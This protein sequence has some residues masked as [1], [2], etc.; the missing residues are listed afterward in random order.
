MEAWLRLLHDFHLL[1]LFLHLLNLGLDPS[2][3]ELNLGALFVHQALLLTPDF[4]FF[5]QLFKSHDEVFVFFGARVQV[6]FCLFLSLC[7]VFL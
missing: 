1:H 7:S 5:A 6:V 2:L 4:V 3:V